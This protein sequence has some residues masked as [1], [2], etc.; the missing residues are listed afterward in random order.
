LLPELTR[1]KVC[2]ACGTEPSTANKTGE[3]RFLAPERGHSLSP[4]RQGCLLDGEIPLWLEAVKKGRWAEA[5]EVMS[6][7][8]PFPAL[9][10][11]VCFHPCSE[12]CNR[13]ELDEA[14]EIEAVERKIGEWRH[15]NYEPSPRR[16]EKKGQVA[17]VGSGPAGLSCAYYLNE[18]GYAVKV[19]ERSSEIGGMFAL[20]IPEYR[21]PRAVLRKETELL[22]AEGIEFITGCSIGKDLTLQELYDQYLQVFVATGAW[23]PRRSDLAG[24][25]CEG[26]WNALD[27]LSM[28]NS[29]RVPRLKDPVAV[30]GGGNAAIDSARSALRMNGINHVSLIYRRSRVEMPAD[31][32]EVEAAEREG[33]ELIFNALP[34]ETELENKAVKGL[35]LDHCKTCRTGLSI[36]SS[37][38]FRKSCGTVIMALG[39]EA[40]YSIFEGLDKA[41][42]IFAGGDLVSGPSTVPEAIRAGRIAAKA[43]VARIEKIPGP[44]LQLPEEKTVRF[45]DLNLAA[46]INLELQ[47]RQNNPIAEAGRCLGCGTCNSCGICYLFCPDMAVDRVDDRYQ[48]NLDYCKGCGICVT[49]CPARALIMKGG[50]SDAI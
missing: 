46:K 26:V 48:L 39:Q 49:E 22:K 3:W 40:D 14:I 43:I 10:G 44:A 34:R 21:L 16:R 18:S 5:W 36:D 20:G 19:Y 24:E 33:V 32:K 9:T 11:Y 47:Q 28:V 42:E 50:R 45:E 4:C 29:G 25:E 1:D 12:N 23:L 31:R 37:R 6:R 13:G 30:I 15:S 17:I 41:P 38:S 27:F 8:N 7:Y 2:Y 35:L